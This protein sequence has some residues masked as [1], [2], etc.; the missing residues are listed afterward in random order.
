MVSQVYFF[1][2]NLIGYTRIILAAVAFYYAERYYGV[3]FVCYGLSALMDEL[4][5]RFARKFNQ[6]SR[7]GAVL[8]MV[9]DRSATSCLLMVL[10]HFY[11]THMQWYL[12]CV[13]LDV[14]SHY[15]HMYSTL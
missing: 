1:I 14:M 13:A 2:P 5:G 4:D 7:F 9:T 11:P 12:L 6:C 15:A 10:G 3:F 8:D